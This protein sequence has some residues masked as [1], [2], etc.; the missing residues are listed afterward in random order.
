MNKLFSSLNVVSQIVDI[1]KLRMSGMGSR[2]PL[3]SREHWS[4]TSSFAGL[5]PYIYTILKISG[6]RVRLWSSE[7]DTN[8]NNRHAW[9]G[10]LSSPGVNMG[11]DLDAFE[12]SGE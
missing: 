4:I 5:E 6:F 10:T 12:I 9:E 8:I 7:G 2:N 3:S 1:I 11:T